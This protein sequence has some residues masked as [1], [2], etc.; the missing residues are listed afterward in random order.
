MH[1][2]AALL[3]LALASPSLC[4]YDSSSAVKALG[5]AALTKLRELDSVHLVEFYAPWY[6]STAVPRFRLDW[7]SGIP[8]LC[9]QV[10]V[11]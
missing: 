4:F 11:P 5:P 8:A 6:S 9:S 10:A 7:L 3:L 2:L 1:A